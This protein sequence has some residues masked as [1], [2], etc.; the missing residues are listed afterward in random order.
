MSRLFMSH[1]MASYIAAI[2]SLIIC[3]SSSSSRH[4][5]VAAW[6]TTDYTDDN[7]MPAWAHTLNRQVEERREQNVEYNKRRRL[8][9]TSNGLLHVVEPE[10]EE[11]DDFNVVLKVKQ[12]CES[13]VN[14]AFCAFLWHALGDVECQARRDADDTDAPVD[15]IGFFQVKHA[16]AVDVLVQAAQ[17]AEAVD[18]EGEAML[19]NENTKPPCNTDEIFEIVEVDNPFAITIDE[20]HH[21]VHTAIVE[22]VGYESSSHTRGNTSV[23]IE[24]SSADISSESPCMETNEIQCIGESDNWG[25]DRIDQ[26]QLPLDGIYNPSHNGTNVHV[27]VV[28]TGGNME[29][30]G[31]AGILGESRNFVNDGQPP[32][33]VQGHGT[34]CAGIA[35]SQKYG[36]A[37]DVVLHV[38]KSLRDDGGGSL[39]DVIEGFS[40]AV[41]ICEQ[42]NWQCVVSSSLGGTKSAALNQ[43][44]ADVVSAGIVMT[45][46]A[47]NTYHGDACERSPCTGTGVICVGASGPNDAITDFSS[48]GQCVT[49]FA[50]GQSIRSAYVGHSRAFAVM[51]GT[52]MATP[53]VAGAAALVLQANPGATPAQVKEALLS[54]AVNK[55]VDGATPYAAGSPRAL[56]QVPV[57]GEAA[58]PPP[59]P[60]APV[61]CVVSAWSAWSSCSAP[62]GSSVPSVR[63]RSVLVSAAN[64]GTA[65]P[66]ELEQ[67]N[68]NCMDACASP[69]PEPEQPKQT[70]TTTTINWKGMRRL[71]MGA[72][73]LFFVFVW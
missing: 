34:H 56:L 15:R 46:S 24:S 18:A 17:F 32:T 68:F 45:A 40:W 58:A 11:K 12:G 37:K 20:H 70:T 72:A 14:V 61:D 54:A 59:P 43:A 66:I 8:D 49:I 50:P 22:D 1:M 55:Q 4:M 28:D 47:G 30:E 51:S 10:D 33:D 29:Y 73:A 36:V 16:S 2:T 42:N 53:H 25:L 48:G 63:K 7:M 60:L 41:S 9:E 67:F 38:V 39:S 23:G 13:V 57:E 62:C 65:C 35:A 64:G 6:G 31:F 71:A 69:P 26:S 27:F 3:C 5:F 52:S 44:A 21:Q 19:G